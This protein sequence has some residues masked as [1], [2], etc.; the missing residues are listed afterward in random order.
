MTRLR[1]PVVLPGLVLILVALAWARPLNHDESQYVAAALL[2]A[3]GHLPYRDFAYLQ[4]PLQPVLLAPIAAAAGEWVWPALRLINALLGAA[5]LLSVFAAARCAGAAHRPALAATMLFGACD[6]FLFSTGTARNDALPAALMA[7][8]LIPIARARHDRGGAALAGFLLA[9]AA[10]AKVSYALPAGAYGLYALVDRRHRPAWIAAGAAP[11]VAGVAVAS[12][13]DPAAFWFSTVTFP[14]MAPEEYYH[15]TGRGWRTGVGAKLVDTLKFLAFGPA[16]L[17]IPVALRARLR[18]GR[19]LDVLLAAAVVA[20]VLPTPTWRQYL[21][22]MLPI[23]FVRLAIALSQ[24]PPGRRL[25]YAFAAFAVIGF[26]PTIVSLASG[27]PAMPTAIRAADAVDD[28]LDAAGIDDGVVTLAPELLAGRSPDPRF[29]AG[30]F[31][32]R[33]RALLDAADE[34]AFDLVSHRRLHLLGRPSA[35]LTGA[36]AWTSG[37]PRLDAVL[38]RWARDN[39]YRAHPLSDRLTLWLR[40]RADASPRPERR[41]NS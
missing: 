30:P 38:D 31:Y 13:F 23:L 8:A 19:A 5:L 27:R 26:V 7:A 18:D 39:G 1:L 9:A 12:W 28:R 20:S 37:D 15:A 22:P 33:S 2:V 21:L 36:E 16:L 41:N 11:V 32:F 3:D 34:Q 35:L 25:R 10:A 14:A 24:R 6:I 29:S 17:A 4:T 40:P